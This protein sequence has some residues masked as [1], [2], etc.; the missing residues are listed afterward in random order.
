MFTKLTVYKSDHYMLYPLPYTVLYVK[1]ISI[2]L[3]E[4]KKNH[5][6]SKD[7]S[8]QKV[9]TGVFKKKLGNINTIDKNS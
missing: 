1:H 9:K 2:K 3:Q 4:K 8:T 5:R 6:N 7:L